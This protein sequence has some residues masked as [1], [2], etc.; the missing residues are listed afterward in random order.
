MFIRCSIRNLAIISIIVSISV[1]SILKRVRPRTESGH[2]SGTITITSND[3]ID[4]VSVFTMKGIPDARLYHETTHERILIVK[5][6]W[7]LSSAISKQELWSGEKKGG[8]STL[9]LARM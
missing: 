9:V 4:P 1:I 8:L 3:N 2:G 6:L 5:R 7:L